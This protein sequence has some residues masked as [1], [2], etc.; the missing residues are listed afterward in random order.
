MLV[1]YEG[2]MKF[3]VHHRGLELTSDQ[4][5]DGGGADSAMTPVE[6]FVASLA[7]CVGVYAVTFARRHEIAVEG[8]EIEV[9]H[10][11]ANAPRRL[12]SLNVTV[13]LPGAVS[14]EHRKAVQ[15]AAE[16]CVIHNTLSHPPQ[17]R[18]AV[19]SKGTAPG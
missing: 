18:I 4:P 13:V 7:T 14:E 17:T 11:M 5:I 19:K 15:R 2:G 1:E 8:L 6:I 16:S 12:A 3:V 10:T 9:Q